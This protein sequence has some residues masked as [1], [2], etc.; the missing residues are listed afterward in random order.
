[1]LSQLSEGNEA[2]QLR[3][4]GDSPSG[5]D[6]EPKIAVGLLQIDVHPVDGLRVSLVAVD[7]FLVDAPLLLQ[8][9]LLALDM[10]ERGC[11]L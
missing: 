2:I 9:E 7:C 6:S 4:Q 10:E 8:G 3:R 5:E 1:M 11:L